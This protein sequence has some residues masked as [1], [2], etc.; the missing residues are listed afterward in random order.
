[1]RTLIGLALAAALAGPVHASDLVIQK[2]KHT[3]AVPLGDQ[4]RPA[5]DSVQTLWVGQDRMRS[6]EGN[7]VT[8]V[9][10]DLK[11]MYILDLDAKTCSTVDLPVDLTK[12]VRPELAPMIEKTMSMTKVTI[13]PTTET[14]KI[15]DWSATRYTVTT[16]ASSFQA[17]S[18]A[19]DGISTTTAGM[20]SGSSQD[21]WVTKDVVA[22]PAGWRDMYAAMM[23]T[24]PSTA[25]LANGM[26]QLDGLPVLVERSRMIG[27]AEVKSHEAVT[28]IAAKDPPAGLYEVPAGFT[29]KPFEPLTSAPVRKQ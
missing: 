21:V 9:R 4:T 6:E 23:S 26:R 1:M 16:E 2:E 7:K 29:E 28:S 27:G 5:R 10:M 3:D 12:Y 25:A 13:T 22:C 20:V 19:A 18:G 15:K 17:T 24:S 11:V 8:I 14:R